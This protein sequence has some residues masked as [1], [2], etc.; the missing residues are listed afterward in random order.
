MV[1]VV[2]LSTKLNVIQKCAYATK[3]NG[4]LGCTR[5][6]VASRS[7][8]VI[9]PLYSAQVTPHLECCDGLSVQGHTGRECPG[10]GDGDDEGTG[11]SLL[12]LRED[13]LE[14]KIREDLVCM[15]INT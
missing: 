9:L 4:I 13:S 14:K 8:E 6:G 11:A 10:K 7:R 15:Y 1:L 3:T 2:L 12:R 5:R